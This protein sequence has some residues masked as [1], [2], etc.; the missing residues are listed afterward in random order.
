MGFDLHGIGFSEDFREMGEHIAFTGWSWRPLLCLLRFVNADCNLRI[1]MGR[2]DFNGVMGIRS[3]EDCENLAQK[4]RSLMD[5]T[6]SN[7]FGEFEPINGTEIDKKIKR[8]F[9]DNGFAGRGGSN[10]SV[11]RDEIEEF[12]LFLTYCGGFEIH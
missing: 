2:W 7:E 6:K 4:L 8:W 9:Q 12:I 1:D 10:Y 3:R 5:N 11:T